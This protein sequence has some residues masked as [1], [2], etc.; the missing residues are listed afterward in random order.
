MHRTSP[1]Q[2][3]ALFCKMKVIC[4]PCTAFIFPSC[5]RYFSPSPQQLEFK[6][7]ES[8]YFISTSTQHNLYSRSAGYCSQR[9]M[10]LQFRY[11]RAS[12]SFLV[13]GPLRKKTLFEA[14]RKKIR[15]KN[16]TTKNYGGG[17]G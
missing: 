6:P 1:I 8:Y 12:P 11:V 7:G 13:A 5:S 3:K 15:K 9:N 4:W 14:Q 16:V 10:R 2:I 17:G